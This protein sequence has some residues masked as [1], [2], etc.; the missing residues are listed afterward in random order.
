MTIRIWHVTSACGVCVLIACGADSGASSGG[1]APLSV[2]SSEGGGGGAEGGLGDGGGVLGDSAVPVVC[3]TSVP[4]DLTEPAV[5]DAC[6][7]FVYLA[8]GDDTRVISSTDEGATWNAVVI[9][10]ISG[11]DVIN[12]FSVFRGVISTSSLPGVF[13][14]SDRGKT[15]TLVNAISNDGFDTYGGQF[16]VG[17]KGL[18]LTDGEGTY[19]AAD[20]VTWQRIVPFPGAP[21]KDGFGKH[22]GGTAF[23]ANTYVALQ[24]TGHYRTYNG[25]KFFDDL[26]PMPIDNGAQ[27]AFGNG[28][29]VVVSGGK[30]TTSADGIAWSAPAPIQ[31]IDG[32]VTTTVNAYTVLF[33]GTRFLAYDGD[34]VALSPDGKTWAVQMSNASVYTAANFDGHF[35]AAGTLN[36]QTAAGILLSKD[37]LSWSSAHTF[38][39]TETA[40]IN[41]WRVGVGRVL[42]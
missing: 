40:F 42:K 2:P 5:R 41:G 8:G 26:M 12:N 32:G 3:P 16:N 19:L 1:D 21:E 4:A 31:A 39:S 22:W 6:T 7:R 34:K 25:T 38:A 13:Q 29:F 36:G 37:G 27:V 17:N 14:S 35:V 24:D 11:D 15:F 18:L 10:D 33:D 30:A 20:G 9:K 23:G 28:K